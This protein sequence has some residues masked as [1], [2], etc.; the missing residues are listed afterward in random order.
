MT[1]TKIQIKTY[2]GSVLFEYSKKDNTLKQTLEKAVSEGANLTGA[3]LT[4]ANLRDANLTGANLKKIQATTQII[5]ETG[6]FEAWKKGEN[7][8][9]IKL[10]IPAKAKRHNYIGGRKC[11]AEFAKVLDIRNSKGHKIKEC[12]NGPH[13]IKTTYLVGEI[14]KPDK[15]DPDPLTECS[16]GIHF[17]ISK[18]EAKDW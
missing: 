8:H 17:F 1:K 15:Y 10:E 14:V 11:R 18:Q 16:N 6:S 3:N 12:R 9:L 13:G 7:D 5:P 4:G 2:W